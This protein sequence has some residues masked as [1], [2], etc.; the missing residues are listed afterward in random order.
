MKPGTR[1]TIEA[2][3]LVTLLLASDIVGFAIVCLI[4]KAIFGITLGG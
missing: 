1:N 3:L 2:W 4:V